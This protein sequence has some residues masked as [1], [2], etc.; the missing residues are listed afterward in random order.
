M[1]E[2][3]SRFD[4]I[5]INISTLT[6]KLTRISILGCS[7]ASRP[8]AEPNPLWPEVLAVAG[9]AV[10]LALAL[11]EC[12]AVHPLVADEAGEAGLVPRLPAR[13]HQLCNED[14]LAA[15]RA[16]LSS[17]PLWHLL[18]CHGFLYRSRRYL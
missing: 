3:H 10:D 15:P 6:D 18:C 8:D 7:Q 16:D 12:A 5:N 14:R 11:A 17:A 2:N 4:N 13:P 1:N 9:L